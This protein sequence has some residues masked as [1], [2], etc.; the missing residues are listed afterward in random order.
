MLEIVSNYF[1]LNEGDEIAAPGGFLIDS[2]SQL[3]T[4][5]AQP[6]DHQHGSST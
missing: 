1:G 5:D 4:G 2:E 3:K 6:R